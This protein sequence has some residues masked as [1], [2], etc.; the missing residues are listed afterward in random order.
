MYF[1]F[2]KR[3]PALLFL[4]LFLFLLC[5]CSP[6]TGAVLPEDIPDLVV[7]TCQEKAVY[8]P[9]I[10]EFRERSGLNVQVEAGT[11]QQLEQLIRQD[12]LS[13]RYDVVFGIHTADLEN[14]LTCWE[15]Y[16][17]ESALSLTAPARPDHGLWTGLLSLQTVIMYNTKV[18]TYQE[19]PTSWESLLDPALK[20]RIA[21][22]NPALSDLGCAVLTDAAYFSPEPNRYLSTLAENLDNAF[23]PSLAQVNLAVTDGRC[24]LGITL[25]PMAQKLKAEGAGIDYFYPDGQN[26]FQLYGSALVS[27]CRQPDAAKALI[28]FSI[29]EE[30]QSLLSRQLNCGSVTKDMPLDFAFDPPEKNG[31]E[32][33]RR[34]SGVINQWTLLTASIPEEGG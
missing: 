8:A 27:G 28:D 19:L 16:T 33:I 9:L 2:F 13:S 25:A 17:S 14:H 7:F 22:L 15:A 23:L 18:V 10:K 26:H 32:F 31:P 4:F 1:R 20:G 12:D 24:S 21:F 6:K 3:F 34:R 5:G 30:V 11:F 29:S